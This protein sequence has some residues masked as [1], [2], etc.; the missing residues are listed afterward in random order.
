MGSG[1]PA[2]FGSWVTWVQVQFP[3]LGPIGTLQIIPTVLQVAYRFKIIIT[4][5]KIYQYC[6]NILLSQKKKR[7][8][9][10]RETYY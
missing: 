2:V 7:N 1:L 4:C 9:K 3:D 10:K 8:L 6:Y 5:N